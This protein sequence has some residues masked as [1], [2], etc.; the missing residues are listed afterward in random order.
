MPPHA[1]DVAADPP[2]G[3]DNDPEALARR[4]VRDMWNYTGG[5]PGRWVPLMIIEERLAMQDESATTAALQ[6]AIEKLWLEEF[7]GYNSIRLT[8]VGRCNE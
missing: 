2:A 5:L 1:A 4:I 6:F 3:A 7:G 8:D